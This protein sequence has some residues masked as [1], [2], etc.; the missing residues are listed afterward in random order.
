MISK[1][2]KHVRKYRIIYIIYAL[3]LVYLLTWLPKEYNT[4][5]ERVL[6]RLNSNGIIKETKVTFEGD[7]IKPIYGRIRY[8]GA[9]IIDDEKYNILELKFDEFNRASIDGLKNSGES[10]SLGKIYF[11]ESYESFTIT[12]FEKSGLNSGGWNSEDGLVITAPA[13]DRL[14]AIE[15]AN[16]HLKEMTSKYGMKNL[17]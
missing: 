3:I 5:F 16:Y 17:E 14:E 11:D 12:L 13:K 7:I 6:Y 8:S 1:I 10:F 15:L 2:F 9:I 4:S